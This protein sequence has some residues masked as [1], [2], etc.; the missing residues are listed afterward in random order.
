MD[1]YIKT[2]FKE[3]AAESTQITGNPRKHQTFSSA[4]CWEYFQKNSNFGLV[5]SS[6]NIQSHNISWEH[7]HRA[8]LREN[9]LKMSNRNFILALI[10]VIIADQGI[11]K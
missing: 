3:A 6:E 10:I 2:T 1:I 4:F 9:N 7:L 8:A 11:L 5:F